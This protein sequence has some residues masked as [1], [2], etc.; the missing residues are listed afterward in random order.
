MNQNKYYFPKLVKMRERPKLVAVRTMAGQEACCSWSSFRLELTV[1]DTIPPA[2]EPAPKPWWERQ[3]SWKNSFS[4]SLMQSLVLQRGFQ[5][6]QGTLGCPH[7][8]GS[9]SSPLSCGFTSSSNL[10]NGQQPMTC[11]PAH[12]SQGSSCVFTLLP[13][14]TISENE[15]VGS[16]SEL[17]N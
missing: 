14:E 13:R 9:I 8:P 16:A 3:A 7:L 17:R 4:G 15:A 12:Q 11:Y 2:S 6:N 5:R 10:Q 1:A